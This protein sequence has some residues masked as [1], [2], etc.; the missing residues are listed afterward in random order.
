MF[1]SNIQCFSQTHTRNIEI[2]PFQ[3]TESLFVGSGDMLRC[4][5]RRKRYLFRFRNYINNNVVL[6]L[7]CFGKLYRCTP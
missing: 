5:I 1:C 3:C 6:I 7:I 2:S 4:I